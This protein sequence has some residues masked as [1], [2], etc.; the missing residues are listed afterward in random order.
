MKHFFLENNELKTKLKELNDKVDI[1]K[2]HQIFTSIFDGLE[3]DP[4]V[5]AVIENEFK[6]INLYIEQLNYFKKFKSDI[7]LKTF[8]AI[9]NF[10]TSQINQELDKAAMDI[11]PV[12]KTS[13]IASDANVTT[14]IHTSSPDTSSSSN[15]SSPNSSSSNTTSLYNTTFFGF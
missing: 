4:N 11:G 6:F 12:L 7:K 15:V 8:E 2:R 14:S 5:Q 10:F 9:N 13:S 1:T 3:N